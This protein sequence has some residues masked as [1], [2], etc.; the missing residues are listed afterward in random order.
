MHSVRYLEDRQAELDSAIGELF[1]HEPDL[2]GLEVVGTAIHPPVQHSPQK[3]DPEAERVAAEAI[4]RSMASGLLIAGAQ[5]ALPPAEEHNER[6]SRVRVQPGPHLAVI[7]TDDVREGEARVHFHAA[8]GSAASASLV[9]E[10]RGTTA[11]ILAWRKV[12]AP[13]PLGKVED[14]AQRFYFDHRPVTILPGERRSLPVQFRTRVGGMFL[15]TWAASV[16]PSVGLDTEVIFCGTA[17]RED[18]FRPVR[19]AMEAALEKALITRAIK[20]MLHAL[21][22]RIHPRNHEAIF[23][24][25]PPTL[26]ERFTSA[27]TELVAREGWTYGDR[28]VRDLQTLH[29][30]V[31]CQLWAATNVPAAQS[32]EESADAKGAK[33]E[34]TPVEVSIP[35]P[36]EWDLSVAGLKETI[37]DLPDW[38]LPGKVQGHTWLRTH[39]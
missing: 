14:N 36:E 5:S 29:R 6:Q 4:A 19:D 26:E 8:V 20:D 30:R 35:E 25:P 21:I 7:G 33:K 1:E 38:E 15:E 28:I 32:T 22:T 13:N 39:E 11:L 31:T 27:N 23:G 17:T 2:D 18:E 34:E 12:E 16:L 24:A 37:M 10:N 9:L 3:A